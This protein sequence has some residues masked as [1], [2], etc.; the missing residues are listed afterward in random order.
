MNGNNGKCEKQPLPFEIF[1]NTKPLKPNSNTW[2][3]LADPDPEYDDCLKKKR[4]HITTGIMHKEKQ[5]Q[6]PPL[7][8]NKKVDCLALL[9]LEKQIHTHHANHCYA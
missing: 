9:L 5:P 1:P 7:P 4:M 8:S 2:K 3:Q 6:A